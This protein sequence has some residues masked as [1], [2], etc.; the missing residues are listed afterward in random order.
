MFIFSTFINKKSGHMLH[1]F[2]SFRVMIS[3]STFYNQ[4]YLVSKK[5][6]VFLGDIELR[7][8]DIFYA[9]N[10]QQMVIYE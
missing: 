2:K 9:Q 10:L 8:M 7:K 3:M 6:N 5:I 4:I 1:N